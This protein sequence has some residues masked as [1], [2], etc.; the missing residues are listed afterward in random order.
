MPSSFLRRR[1]DS[2]RFALAG[3][4]AAFWTEINMRIHLAAA[5]V[6][7]VVAFV[8]EVTATEWCLLIFCIGVVWAAEIFNTALEALVNLVSPVQHPLAGKVKDLAAGAVLVTAIM[9]VVVG[10]I[11]F[12]PHLLG[13]LNP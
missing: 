7:V 2:F 12:G 9:A 6:V 5:L 4:R 3:I 10:L 8:L 13:W 11:I 1:I